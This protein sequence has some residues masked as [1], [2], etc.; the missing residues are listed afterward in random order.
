LVN[1][2]ANIQ[3]EVQGHKLHAMCVFLYGRKSEKKIIY[4]MNCELRKNE[5]INFVVIIKAF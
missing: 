2:L 1:F 4:S 3:G 5:M